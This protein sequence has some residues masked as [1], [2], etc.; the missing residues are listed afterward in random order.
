MP[1]RKA[2]I[3]GAGIGGLAAGIAL[4][5]AGWTVAV[6][7]AAP[8]P[9]E[10]GAGLTLWPNA[11][12]ALHH[13]G[14]TAV[15]EAAGIVDAQ[16][17]TIADQD[18]RVLSAVRLPAEANYPIVVVHRVEFQ[19][20]L[21]AAL[22]SAYLHCGA[23]LRGYLPN[24][25]GQVVALFADG[26]EAAGDLLI[27]AD[28]IHSAT[29]RQ[30]YGGHDPAP[31]YAGHTAWRATIPFPHRQIPLWGEFWGRGDRFGI[32]PLSN[33]RIYY[34]ATHNAPPGSDRHSTP[35]SRIAQLQQRFAH[36][37]APIPALIAAT[38]PAALLQHDISDL[39]PLPYWSAGRV[40]LL[41][42]A[43]HATTPNLGQGA[44][45]ALED[46]VVLAATL[47][48]T[49]DIPAAL[50]RYAAKRRPRTAQIQRQSRQ[51]GWAAQ[52]SNPLAVACRNR[53]IGLVPQ[54]IQI[55]TFERIF[56]WDPGPA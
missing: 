6:Y 33:D 44:C 37:A 38:D 30:L 1:V 40:T 21:I 7:E 23:R 50:Q 11:L 18:G 17:G 41:G 49:A 43:A 42:D 16:S 9:H 31:T 54:A 3:I 46:A 19:A 25:R 29:R 51:I 52:W 28:G 56:T 55:K 27:G 24:E 26:R 53:A 36:W 15:I 48:D 14:L 34:F 4:R 8:A 47:R 45:L 22:G 32:V 12:E 20:L 35:T 2:I 5:Q 13:L 10:V 39:P